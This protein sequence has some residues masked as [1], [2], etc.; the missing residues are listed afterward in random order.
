MTT[1]IQGLDSVGIPDEVSLFDVLPSTATEGTAYHYLQ[2][3][4]DGMFEEMYYIL[5]CMH[6]QNADPEKVIEACREIVQERNSQILKK[7][8]APDNSEYLN[9]VDEF[10]SSTALLDEQVCHDETKSDEKQ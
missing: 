9:I 4:G 8:E 10:Y 1:E 7:F 3:F 5:E 6:R 2:M